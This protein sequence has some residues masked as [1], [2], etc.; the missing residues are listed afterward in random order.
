V[1]NFFSLEENKVN[2]N[3][4]F[5]NNKQSRSKINAK[6][7]S[8]LK[9]MLISKAGSE[10]N[11]FGSTTQLELNFIYQRNGMVLITG[12]IDNDEGNLKELKSSQAE[13]WIMY[14]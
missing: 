11:G 10:K 8:E 12:L 9:I 5:I 4:F 13:V 1:E 7:G 2:S 3:V 14:S 6:A